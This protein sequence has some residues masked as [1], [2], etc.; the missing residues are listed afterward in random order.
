MRSFGGNLRYASENLCVGLTA[1]NY[2]FGG[3]R[4]EPEL[5]PYNLYYFW[6]EENTNISV[7]YMFRRGAIKF[8]GETAV[9]KNK[10]IATLN[11][12][13]IQPTSYASF[14]LLYRN[15]SK[16]YQA[17]YGNAFGQNS[18]V[19][20]EEGVYIGMQ[21]T[22]FPYWKLSAY[23][24]VFRFPWLKYGVDT[25]S[26]G[27]EYMMQ[28]EHNRG[29]NTSFSLRY[30]YKQ[31]EKNETID[32]LIR[33]GEA[34]QHRIRFQFT[35][36]VHNWNLRTSL[37]GVGYKKESTNMNKGWM[38]GQGIYYQPE[39][40]K[41][42]GDLYAA[43]FDTDNSSITINS[44][45][46]TPLYV[47]YKPSFYGQGMRLACSLRYDISRQLMLTL[48]FASTHYFDRDKIGTELEEIEGSDKTDLNV[49]LRWKF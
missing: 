49:I 17:V 26:S 16:K 44:F 36:V 23:A 47:Y 25:P 19:Q 10:A 21:L 1:L 7:D 38:I 46:R 8:Y 48:K 12:L 39:K 27:E 18:T 45:E 20:N 43:Y 5:K 37:D 11:G 32:N 4:Y 42:R 35:Q 31:T 15:Y 33:I 2:S 24:D 22:P 40:G 6:G 28:M 13:Q 29:R 14:L 41:L 3:K 9:S 30:R 34:E